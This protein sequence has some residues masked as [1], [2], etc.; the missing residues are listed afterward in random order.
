MPDRTEKSAPPATGLATLRRVLVN[1][2]SLLTSD[3][4]N[5]AATFVVYVL[6]ARHCG[7]HSFGQLS[8]GLMLLYTFQVFAGAGLP[9]LVTRE[10]AR[11]RELSGRYLANASV[12]AFGACFLSLAGLVFLVFVSRY[13]AD[14]S[15][16]ILLLGLGIVPCSLTAI[17]NAV[18]QA[19]EKMHVIVL[20]AIPV[21]AAK[22]GL[23]WYL[24][25]RGH[26]VDAIALVLLGCHLATLLLEWPVL[27]RFIH[28]REVGVELAFCR[29]LLRGTW[30]FLGIDSLLALWGSTNTLLL[31]WFA[32]EAAVGLFAAAWQLLVPVTMTFQAVVNGLFPILCRRAD[33]D[34]EQFRRLSVLLLEVLAIVAVPGCILLYFGA[35]SIIALVYGA[36]GFAGSVAVMR[37]IVPMLLLQVITLTLGHVLFSQ[38]QEHRSLRIIAVDVAFNAICGT[39]LIYGFGLVGAATTVL[40]TWIVNASL[41]IAAARE[42]L[43]TA[44]GEGLAWH[45]T[46]LGN[47]AAAGF[48]M[49]AALAFSNHLN[50]LVTSIITSFLY[51]VVLA[52]LV[53]AACRGPLGLRERF[54]VPLK[55]H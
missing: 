44:G 16:V 1:M 6:V 23:S 55:E 8:L 19:W 5:R 30:R 25:S 20:V 9:V 17:A 40:L 18:L 51:L 48:V 11:Q 34:R 21:N 15:K 4:L 2:A 33:A 45:T 31:S 3:V 14:T 39:A 38:R 32:G 26:D 12:I 49:A 10:V 27:F 37:L 47:I 36:E 43:K 22:V 54:L 28:M 35:D 50:F 42:W 52:T 41:H 24:L 13:P 29:E 46:I 7:A 53:L